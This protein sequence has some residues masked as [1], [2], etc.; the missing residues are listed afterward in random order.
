MTVGD[1]TAEVKVKGRDEFAKL[2][3]SYNHMLS[4]MK[5]LMKLTHRQAEKTKEESMR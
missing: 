5:E 4:N 1:L 3:G 2:G